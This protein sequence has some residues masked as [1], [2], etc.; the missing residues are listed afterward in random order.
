VINNW[1]TGM[2]KEGNEKFMK[3]RF[4][5]HLF[6]KCSITSVTNAVS[7]RKVVQRLKNAGFFLEAIK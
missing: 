2:K 5:T 7:D 1:T 4:I 3:G 6:V